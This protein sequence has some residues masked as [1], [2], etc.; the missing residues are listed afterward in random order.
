MTAS[1]GVARTREWL[2]RNRLGHIEPSAL[3][4]ERLAA[5]RRGNRI[6][7]GTVLAFFVILG[8]WSVTTGRSGSA[9]DPDETD[10]SGLVFFVLTNVA[11]ILALWAGLWYAYRAE[12]RLLAASRTRTAHPAAAGVA[13]VLGR[14]HLAAVLVVH[15]GGLLLGAATALLAPRPPDRALALAFLGSVALLSVLSG[16]A[17]AGVLRRPSVAEDSDS[18]LVDDVLRTQDTRAAVAP[19]P[20][21]VALV[22]GV[23]STVGSWLIWSFLAYAGLGCVCWAYA[24]LSARRTAPV[25]AG[26]R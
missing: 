11:L 13:R 22:A 10:V 19:F 15:G 14:S 18:L 2:G 5:R 7:V 23:G 12:R 17:V 6:N 8:A 21:L 20:I 1:I 26:I 9:F 4:V 16:L 3:L 25:P 24:E